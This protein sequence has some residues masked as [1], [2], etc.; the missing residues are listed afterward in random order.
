M[1]FVRGKPEGIRELKDY[2]DGLD[3]VVEVYS[4]TSDGY[5]EFDLPVFHPENGGKYHDSEIDIIFAAREVNV[6]GIYVRHTPTEFRILTTLVYRQDMVITT[7]HIAQLWGTEYSISPA[8]LRAYVK[9]LRRNVE[10]NPEDPKLIETVHG[11]G[12]RYNTPHITS[13]SDRL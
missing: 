6:R 1:M 10:V 5:L 3:V 13:Y 11:F 12:Y 8:N 9:K 7:K 4:E 2:A